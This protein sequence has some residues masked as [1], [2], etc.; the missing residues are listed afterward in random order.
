ML[1]FGDPS[2]STSSPV[3]VYVHPEVSRKS[4]LTSLSWSFLP[5][6]SLRQLHGPSNW[7][8]EVRPWYPPQSDPSIKTLLKHSSHHHLLAQE[9]PLD[10]S[11]LTLGEILNYLAW[12]PSLIL[13]CLCCFIVHHSTFMHF[14]VLSFPNQF[15]HFQPHALFRMKLRSGMPFPLTSHLD[16]ILFPLQKPPILTLCT[17]VECWSSVSQRW[18][19][20]KSL[21]YILTWSSWRGRILYSATKLIVYLVCYSL[22]F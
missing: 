9:Y 22:L 15:M 18:I 20:G 21:R 14:I 11:S 7:L 6:F 3:P 4:P 5:H 2:L 12:T 16:K 1:I 10:V 8:P 13:T 19:I 17:S